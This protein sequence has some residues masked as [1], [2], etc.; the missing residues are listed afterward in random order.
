MVSTPPPNVPI[1]QNQIAF[2]YSTPKVE[3]VTFAGAEA[4]SVKVD[5]IQATIS[6]KVTVFIA[7]RSPLK[8]GARLLAFAKPANWPNDET[9][10]DY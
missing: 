3:Q 10:I 6:P 9:D 7:P 8:A 2:I 5:R 1:V 4:W